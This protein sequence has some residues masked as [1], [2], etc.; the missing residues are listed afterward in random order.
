[1]ISHTMAF[2]IEK[3]VTYR[4]FLQAFRRQNA[5]CKVF[6]YQWIFFDGANDQV[7]QHLNEFGDVFLDESQ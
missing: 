7:F 3:C 4:P 2:S 5:V 6:L 1:M